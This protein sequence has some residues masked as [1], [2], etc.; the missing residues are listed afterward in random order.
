MGQ[1]VRY[2]TLD[3]FTS[4]PYA[5]NPLAVVFLPN[6]KGSAPPLTQSQKLTITREFDLS[7]TIFVHEGSGE[8]RTIDI[9]TTA[10]EIP[11]A[12]HPTI[13]AASW[14]LS[15]SRAKEDGE[16]VRCLVT[17]SGEIPISLQQPPTKHAVVA[18]IAH[19]VRFHAARYPLNELL[20]LHPSLAPFFPAAVQGG[21]D[22]FP[23]VSIVNGMSQVHVELPSLEALAAVTTTYEVV[24]VDGTYLDDGWGSGHCVKYFYVR[25]V[26]DARLGRNVIRTRMILGNEEDAA[27]GS[28]ASGLVA[29]LSLTN[30]KPGQYKYDIVQGVEM[31]RRSDI[32]I[33]ITISPGK[34]IESLDLKG[35]A[36][37]VAEGTI[38]V[39]EE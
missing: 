3:V 25:D 36:V 28:A 32:G 11:F 18:R 12:G 29:Y 31:G 8:K 2:V 20:R 23:I 14:F 16:L 26:A 13:G 10:C 21:V 27:T 17:K 37:M 33:D 39:P 7:E 6:P 5:G 22:S 34:E 9:F 30:G 15:H 24:P 19:N 4:Q 1:R 35:A 38:L